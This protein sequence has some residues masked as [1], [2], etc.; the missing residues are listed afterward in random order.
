MNELVPCSAQN[1]QTSVSRVRE[2][3]LGDKFYIRGGMAGHFR[4]ES[5]TGCDC[6]RTIMDLREILRYLIS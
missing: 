4:K 1:K 5:K 3:D 2:E 6:I